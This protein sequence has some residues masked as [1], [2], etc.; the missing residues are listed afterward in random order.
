M[1]VTVLITFGASALNFFQVITRTA[2][3]PRLQLGLAVVN[4]FL[5]FLCMNLG[6]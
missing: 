3:Y 1:S 4:L 2:Q 5:G 6:V